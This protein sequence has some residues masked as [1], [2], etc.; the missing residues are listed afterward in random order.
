MGFASFFALWQYANSELR[1]NLYHKDAERIG[2]LG[3][4]WDWT[5]DNGKTWEH[6]TF[7]LT[8]PSL[9]PR[10]KEDYPEVE[11]TLRMFGQPGFFQ[12]DLAPHGERIMI[13]VDK[14]HGQED[15]FKETRIAYADENLFEFFTIPLVSGQK[16]K[17]LKEPNSAVL[18]QTTSHKYFGTKIQ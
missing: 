6:M 3:M 10:F 9:P 4:N 11:S 8:K 15:I 12:R 18:S 14:G 1:V 2:R 17:V 7:S 16:E 13:T 5:D